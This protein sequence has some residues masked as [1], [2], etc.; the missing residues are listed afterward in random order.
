LHKLNTQLCGVLTSWSGAVI[1]AY[2]LVPI[3]KSV[4]ITSPRDQTLFNASMQIWNFLVSVAGSLLLERVGRR[5]MWLGAT[6]AML[7]S[8]VVITA[9][10]ALYAEQ[11]NRAAGRV[12]LGFL[13]VFRGS[14]A[15]G[16]SLSFLL[17]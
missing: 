10:S 5:R 7:L 6:V 13:F 3:L 2:Y 14:Y 12:V 15:I 1:V 11:K 17:F 16:V 9:C 8:L 4:G